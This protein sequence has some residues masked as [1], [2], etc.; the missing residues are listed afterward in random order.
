MACSAGGQPPYLAAPRGQVAPPDA[1]GI[2][3]DT[4]RLAENFVQVQSLGPVPVR[5]L[6]AP[7]DVFNVVAAGQVK[8]RFQAAALR[9]LSRFVG[10]DAE[11]EQLRAA[12]DEA[13]HGRGQVVAVTGEPG[14]GKSRLFYEL[15]YSPRVSGC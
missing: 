2:T 10:R 5:G 1:T 14:V 7:V 13:R 9:G 8:T 15:T 6:D 12:L 11:L 3:A 4:F